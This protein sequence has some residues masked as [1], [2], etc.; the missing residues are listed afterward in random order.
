VG[1][2]EKEE[3]ADEELQNLDNIEDEVADQEQALD[4][5]PKMLL[6]QKICV[7]HRAVDFMTTKKAQ[8]F[9]RMIRA[10]LD[11]CH[12]DTDWRCI[13]HFILAEALRQTEQWDEALQTCSSGLSLSPCISERAKTS[14]CVHFLH[15]TAAYAHHAM[16]APSAAKD[17]LTKL[18]ALSNAHFF[19]KAIDFKA[20]HLQR[21]VGIEMEEQYKEIVVPAR[22]RVRFAIAV[23]AGV[24]AVKWDWALAEY[25][26][27]FVATF[28]PQTPG[29]NRFR[30]QDVDQHS[31][32][33]GPWSG[34]LEA[35]HP[36]LLELVF[37]NSFS[38]LRSKDV[39]YRIQ[40][41]GLQVQQVG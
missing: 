37:D 18:A 27:S 31:A 8:E 14:G 29:A 20:T 4:W 21:L 32:E 33:K 3:T 35:A 25:T 5:R 26:L 34:I 17:K 12:D 19:Q 38:V 1:N 28:Q 9:V 36:G 16:G 6:F 41:A 10:E 23:P 24:E 22:N 39:R 11:A 2:Q 30:V 7:V 13:G 15:L 40:P